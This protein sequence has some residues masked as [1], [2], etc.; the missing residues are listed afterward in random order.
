MKKF[1]AYYRVST[2]GQEIS[3]LG[4]EAQKDSVD[5][6]IQNEINRTKT[7]KNPSGEEMCLY[8][9]FKDI[10]TG[11]KSKPTRM[12]LN[13]AIN[14]CRVLLSKGDDVILLIAKIDRL[15]RNVAFIAT[16]RESGIKFVACD[17]PDA[18]NFTMNIFASLAEQEA[19]M[20]SIRTKEALKAFRERTK[21]GFIDSKGNFRMTIANNNLTREGIEKSNRTNKLKSLLDNNNIMA[22][23]Y[24]ITLR[25]MGLSLE[26][27][28]RKMNIDGFRTVNGNSWTKMQIKRLL[29]RKSDFD[30][31]RSS[32][33]EV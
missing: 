6:F 21:D 27:I 18:N 29:D 4:L 25:S 11:T 22:M 5:R 12:G 7:F 31:I 16:L 1:I 13:N 33:I 15:A 30:T 23:N 3:G 20:I 17:M 14:L 8:R 19:E 32:M 26:S 24:A 9:E 2:R 10:E 28:S